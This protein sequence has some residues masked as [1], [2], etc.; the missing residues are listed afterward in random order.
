MLKRFLIGIFIIFAVVCGYAITTRLTI[1][2][3]V[4]KTYNQPANIFNEGMVLENGILYESS[5]LYLT[6]KIIK[7]DLKSEKV[8]QEYKLPPQ[9]FA[10]GITIIGDNLYQLTYKEHVLFVYDKTTLKLKASHSFPF[11]GWGLTTDGKDLIFSNG[12]AILQFMDPNTFKIVRRIIVKDHASPVNNLNSLQ[13]VDNK[14]Y[15]NVYTT[16]KIAIIAAT[17][18]EVLAWLDLAKINK[19]DQPKDY[20]IVPNGI[21]YNSQNQTLFVSG[22][23]WP[24]IFELKLL[25]N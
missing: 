10:E 7:L 18:G 23:F 17:D 4:L 21:A 6:S 24:K 8:I 3:K 14:I 19:F 9:Y 20:R 22:K 12:T 11:E 1:G 2:Y 25:N 13:Y 5:G 15:A 16:N